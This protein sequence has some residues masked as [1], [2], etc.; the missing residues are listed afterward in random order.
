MHCRAGSIYGGSIRNSIRNSVAIYYCF[1]YTFVQSSRAAA[2]SLKVSWHSKRVLMFVI[3]KLS[4]AVIIILSIVLFPITIRT[5]KQLNSS[6][7]GII[8]HCAFGD[9]ARQITTPNSGLHILPPKAQAGIRLLQ[10]RRLDSFRLSPAIA[11]DEE[12]K[13]RLTEG[14]YPIRVLD[15]SAHCLLFS[16]EQVPSGCVVVSRT[17]E[18]ILASCP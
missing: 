3:K 8:T 14:A 12:I 9:L 11:R 6:I 5:A 17:Q 13:Q 7:A 2:Q 18:V 16:N 15:K 1:L 10:E 4:I